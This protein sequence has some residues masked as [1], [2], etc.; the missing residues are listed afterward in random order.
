MYHYIRV[1]P[2]PADPIGVGLS[3]RPAI[4]AAQMDYLA[5]RGYQT[6]TLAHLHQAMRGEAD[7]PPHPIVLTF[8][9][10]YADFYEVAWPVLRQYNFHSTVFVITG[11][12]GQRGYLSRD[13]LIEL[14]RSGLVE[15]G[16]HTVTHADLTLVA[17]ARL[18]WEL[19]ASRRALEGWLGHPVTSFCYP[20]GQYHAGVVAATRAAGYAVAVTTRSGNEHQLDQALEWTRLRVSGPGS[21]GGL[22]SALGQ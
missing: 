21:V 3:V 4:F 15:I 1:P 18:Q 20:S 13:M 5:R 14:D 11:K 12:V 7:L 19:V 8:D 10:G 22:A 9:D 16:A 6:V 2:N 17:P